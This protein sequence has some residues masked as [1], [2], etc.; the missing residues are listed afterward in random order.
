[1]N[2]VRTV[3]ETATDR[4]EPVH[5]AARAGAEVRRRRRRRSRW[6]A[7]AAGAAAAAAVTA[8]IV[9][10]VGWPQVLRPPAGPAV[11]GAATTSP[12]PAPPATAV[13]APSP[14]QRV[15]DPF[16]VPD[17]PQARSPLPPRLELPA[18]AHPP[19]AARPVDG[20]V[21]AWP[22]PG[23]DL[24]LL[25]TDG[26]WRAVPGT[27]AQEP[28]RP[29]I[30]H[31]GRQV[32]AATEAGLL[33]LDATTGAQDLRPWPQQVAPPW[34]RPPDVVWAPGDEEV[35]VLDPRGAWVLGPGGEAREA[36]YA[37]RS[38]VV[39]PDPAGV[40]LQH[41]YDVRTLVTWE[42]DRRA[43]E[44]PFPQ[45]E[46]LVARDGLVACTAGALEPGRSGPVVVEAATGALVAYAPI[47]DPD[48][49]YSDNA[50]LTVL[51]FVDEGTAVLL[52]GPADF[53]RPRPVEDWHLVAWRFRTG[54]LTR[55][56]TGGPE[57]AAVQV[58]APALAG[59]LG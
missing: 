38:P 47:V 46:R 27:A 44:V 24:R 28:G 33:V 53:E 42:G 35:V 12:S 58:H 11:P 49:V 34:D 15:W 29:A 51:G 57:L 36:P 40:V 3:L 9:G 23:A 39:A 52:V 56:A 37:G 10:A 19:I 7:A 20:L 43:A 5:L 16:D 54:D 17:L 50:R 32:A 4:V 26:A 30:S 31:D 25:G 8:V 6:G 55:L 18:A 1:M 2:D 59:D 45:C 41:E 22:R 13:P 48:A 14:T 21:L